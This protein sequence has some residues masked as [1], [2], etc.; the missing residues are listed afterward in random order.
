METFSLV[1]DYLKVHQE[2]LRRM[3]V[4]LGI[5]LEIVE[6]NA[7]KLV[8]ILHPTTAGEVACP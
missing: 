1:L 5:Q 4:S 8:D 7:H 6:E 2:L 3:A